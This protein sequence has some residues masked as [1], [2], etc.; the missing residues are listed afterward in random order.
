MVLVLLACLYV[1]TM[2]LFKNKPT[3]FIPT[4]DEG[5]VYVTF[6]LP[7]ASSTARTLEV[8][9]QMMDMLKQ[10]PGIAHFA[11]LGGLN[12]VTFATKVEQRHRSLSS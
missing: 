3:G 12:V 1:G 11:A 4:E 2:F 6:E 9:N 5:R 7:E 10:T 8:L